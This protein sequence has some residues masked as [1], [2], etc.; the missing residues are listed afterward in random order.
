ML[1]LYSGFS[2]ILISKYKTDS[3]SATGC[4]ELECYHFDL[5]PFM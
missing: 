1:I 4:F 5:W 2:K 3:A